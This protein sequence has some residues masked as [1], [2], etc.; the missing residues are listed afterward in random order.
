MPHHKAKWGVKLNYSKMISIIKSVGVQ[1]TF[2][3]GRLML[4]P[5]EKNA[6]AL[7]SLRHFLEGV[8]E[9]GLIKSPAATLR[10]VTRKQSVNIGIAL[11]IVIHR[12]TKRKG[13]E[14]AA[15]EPLKHLMHMLKLQTGSS[16]SDELAKEINDYKNGVK[17]D[18][19]T[20]Q[21][22]INLSIVQYA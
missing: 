14:Q 13:R 20:R 22:N 18:G 11:P 4:C 15:D 10:K 5:V 9:L 7:N 6:E 21:L 1:L 12:R 19:A 8:G 16:D 17:A 2:V 3:S